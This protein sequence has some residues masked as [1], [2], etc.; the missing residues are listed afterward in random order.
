M[1]VLI[2]HNRYQAE[3]GE[4]R[5]VAEIASL[6]SRAGHTVEALE[7]SSADVGRAR[8]G[9][10]LLIGGVEAE[11]VATA[12]RRLRADV[13]HAHNVHP[14]FG[15]RALA[16][17]RACGART[18]LHLHNYR[19]FCAVGISYRNGRPCF[20]CRGR[21]TLPGL[22]HGC[23]GSLAE[24]I[25]YGAGLSL[26]QPQLLR[27]ADAMVALSGAQHARLVELGVPAGRLSVL[28]NFVADSGFASESR[29]QDGSYVLVSG[30]LVE[31][32]GF[33]V[34]IA[35]ARAASVPLVI[36]G[37]GP[38]ELR[39][40]SLAEGADVRFAGWL[41]APELAHLRSGAAVVLVPSRCEDVCPY[42]VLDALAAGVPV[43]VSDRGG[44]PEIAG[45]DVTLGADDGRAWSA[46][47]RELWSNAALRHERGERALTRARERFGEHRYLE[48][49]LAIYRG[50]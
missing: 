30:R 14:L 48:R 25:A 29:A 18:V 5:A 50:W 31:E 46:A 6:L 32:K 33:D 17:A 23:R 19:L 1:R 22:L 11:A 40:R 44:L 37:A 16:A 12:A 20:D 42:S 49:L 43:L 15:W 9:R 7:R 45:S 3:G 38:D 28:S 35:A 47:L 27:Q 26:Q 41:P 13:V 39:L 21:N 36:A 8:A 34:A 10:S 24:G 4:E 2:V